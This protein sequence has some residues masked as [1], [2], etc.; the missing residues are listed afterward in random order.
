MRI[1]KANTN[2]VFKTT[3]SRM[4]SNNIE[5]NK[6]NNTSMCVLTHDAVEQD[7]D[8][9]QRENMCLLMHDAVEQDKDISTRKHV[10]SNA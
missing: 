4:A 9:Y 5:Y 8:R 6:F 3:K 10:P 1:N 7:K 2:P